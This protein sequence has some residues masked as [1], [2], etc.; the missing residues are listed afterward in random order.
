M[1]IQKKVTIH[2]INEN[3]KRPVFEFYV[4]LIL[5]KASGLTEACI[6]SSYSSYYEKSILSEHSNQY[7]YFMQRW[8][9][10]SN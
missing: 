8:Y 7:T 6:I 10:Q 9:V 3:V 5:L 4:L 1:D 2:P